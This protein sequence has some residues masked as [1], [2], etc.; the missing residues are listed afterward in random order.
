MPVVY[1]ITH[2]DVQMDPGVPV[3]QWPLSPRGRER[4]SG[5]LARPWVRRIRSIYCSNERKACDAAG[6]VADAL[7][8]RFEPIPAL[9]EN[10][11]TASGYL[12]KAEFEAVADQFFARPDESVRGW[13]RA[14]DAQRRIVGAM[15]AV[16]ARMPKDGDIAVLS[17]GAVGA[18]YLCH[19]K[20][21]PISRAEDQPATNGGNY[22]A[23]ETDGMVLLHG[24]QSIDG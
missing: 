11:R 18:L 23:F 22:F 7:K 16:R 2:P 1:F 5:M 14:V 17:H 12:P 24:W 15:D 20:H 3:P 10:D 4:M 8:L 19:L 9:G 6:I 21:C 13:E